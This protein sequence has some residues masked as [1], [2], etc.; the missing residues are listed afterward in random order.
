M[1][2]LQMEINNLARAIHKQ[3]CDDGIFFTSC[4]NVLAIA[5]CKSCREISIMLSLAGIT[6]SKTEEGI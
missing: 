4:V 1:T 3:D 6:L 2:C 5:H